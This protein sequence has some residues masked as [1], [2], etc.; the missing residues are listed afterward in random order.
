VRLC[1]GDANF[2]EVIHTNGNPVWGSGTSDADGKD[3]VSLWWW[4]WGGGEYVVNTTCITH[5]EIKQL[6]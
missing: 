2:T 1:K 4:W 6:F 3:M 5:G